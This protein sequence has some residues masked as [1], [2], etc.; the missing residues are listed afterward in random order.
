MICRPVP[1]AVN[2]SAG[3]GGLLLP[4]GAQRGAMEVHMAIQLSDDLLMV[5]DSLRRLLDEIA[6]PEKIHAWDKADRLP[7]ELILRLA[8]LGICGLAVD[9][10]YGGVGRNVPGLLMVIQ[11]I[12]RR[13]MA[14]AGLYVMCASYAGLNLTEQG[15]T[16]QKQKLLPR[17]VEGKL[18]FAL[19]LSEPD[20]GADLAAVKTRAERHGDT[21]VING[22]KRWCSG[23]A[24]ADFIYALVRSGPVED[25]HRNLSFVLIPRDTPGITMT[26]T[27]TMGIRGVPTND[28]I[29]DNV[30]VPV[31][32]VLGEEAGW[33]QG[34]KQLAG[35]TLEVEKLSPSAMGVGLAEAAVEEAWAYAQERVQFGKRICGHQAV[36]HQLADVQTR[37]QACKLMLGNAA[38]LVH[39]GQ[40]SAVQTSMTKL[41]VAETVRGIVLDCQTVMG[42]YGYAEGFNMERYVRDA[43]VL[44]IFG[45]SSAIQRTNIASLMKLPRE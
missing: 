9:E 16:A 17:V 21:L 36:R 18:L 45:G 2:W 20:V 23:A 4:G 28:V 26:D 29:F 7:P 39:L 35:P 24:F 37:L 1:D 12:A 22:A 33:N 5:R 19:G 10:A 25:R 40:P 41:F 8:E 34:W 44:P 15:S 27:P 43:L 3:A 30:E 38:E 11:E 6:P 14:L 13:S 42:A 31:A 32:N